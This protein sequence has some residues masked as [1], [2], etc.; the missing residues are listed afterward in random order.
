MVISRLL[1][2]NVIYINSE[3]HKKIHGFFVNNVPKLFENLSCLKK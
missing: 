3:N 1:R 2:F